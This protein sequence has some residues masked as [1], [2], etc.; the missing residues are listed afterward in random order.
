[1]AGEERETACPD[2][3]TTAP[4]RFLP[5]SVTGAATPIKLMVVVAYVTVCLITRHRCLG[6]GQPHSV[7]G[8]ALGSPE[9]FDLFLKPG[10]GYIE[11][12]VAC[13][14]R[15]LTGLL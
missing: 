14:L 12:C 7:F 9:R 13:M 3:M 8:G 1:M 15:L 4:G 2:D 10:S 5:H 6:S 11:L